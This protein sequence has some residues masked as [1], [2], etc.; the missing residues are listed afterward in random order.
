MIKS[1]ALV[2]RLFSKTFYMRKLPDK[3]IRLASE[4]GTWFSY[5]ADRKSVV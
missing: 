4:Q 2:K 3:Q 5:L 1:S